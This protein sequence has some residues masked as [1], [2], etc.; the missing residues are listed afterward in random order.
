VRESCISYLLFRF[1]SINILCSFSYQ[2]WYCYSR[3]Q[4][5]FSLQSP[6]FDLRITNMGVTA[7]KVAQGLSW[8]ELLCNWQSVSQSVLALNPSVTLDQILAEEIQL[9][10]WYHGASFLTG[11]RVCLLYSTLCWSLLHLTPWSL[12]CSTLYWSLQHLTL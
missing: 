11:G 6:G 12:L 10:D 1:R 8:A 5:G 3:N 4:A 2:F 7:D 9:R